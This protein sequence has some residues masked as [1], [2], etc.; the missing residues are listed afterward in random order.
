MTHRLISDDFGLT[1]FVCGTA[2]QE[3]IEP[4]AICRGV[5]NADTCKSSDFDGTRPH[6]FTAGP[7]GPE[8]A[9]CGT[10]DK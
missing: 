9:Y 1:C 7:H 10:S 4:S 3:D 6:T 5:G 8:C 2:W